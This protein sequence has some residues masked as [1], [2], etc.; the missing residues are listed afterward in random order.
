MERVYITSSRLFS[1]G[2][3]SINQILEIE[4]SWGGVYQYHDVPEEVY[5]NLLEAKSPGKYFERYV[6]KAGF[7]FEKVG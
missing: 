4:F 3:D 5:T 2:Y 1:V 6:N 7:E